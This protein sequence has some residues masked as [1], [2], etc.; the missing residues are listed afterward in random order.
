MKKNQ[1]KFVFIKILLI[2]LNFDISLYFPHF[3]TSK[4]WE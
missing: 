1:H 3:L 4:K 2:H